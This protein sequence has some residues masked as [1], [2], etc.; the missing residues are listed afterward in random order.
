MILKA[1]ETIITNLVTKAPVSR[2]C[3]R[4]TRYQGV[5]NAVYEWYRLAREGLVPMSGPMLQAEAL[6]PT[7][8][9]GN[10]SFKVSNG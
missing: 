2:K 3:S 4:G 9:L 8:Y 6:L 5:N 10:N 1:K 7:K